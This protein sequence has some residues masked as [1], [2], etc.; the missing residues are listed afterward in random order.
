MHQVSVVRTE[1]LG[2][3]GSPFDCIRSIV[4]VETEETAP[5]ELGTPGETI[6]AAD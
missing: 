4:D 2:S 1:I 6:R 5:Q 3:G